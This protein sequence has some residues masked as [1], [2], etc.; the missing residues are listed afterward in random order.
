MTPSILP[1]AHKTRTRR[2]EIPHFSAAFDTLIYSIRA[3][4][5]TKYNLTRYIISHFRNNINSILKEHVKLSFLFCN[6]KGIIKWRGQPLARVER[7]LEM[8]RGEPFSKGSPRIYH[9]FFFFFKASTNTVEII[10]A[11]PTRSTGSNFTPSHR[12]EI[13]ALAT[14]SIEA[15]TL[16]R[17]GPMSETA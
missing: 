12:K 14:G 17:T 11:K 6:S 4:S 13:T 3:S 15:S 16:A 10:S 9:S 7:L 5:Q 8:G 1:S 2:A